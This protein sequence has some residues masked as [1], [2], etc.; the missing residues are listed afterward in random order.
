MRDKRSE[1][2]EFDQQYLHNPLKTHAEY[3][4][5]DRKQSKFIVAS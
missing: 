2:E 3:E 5:K 1:S 4:N